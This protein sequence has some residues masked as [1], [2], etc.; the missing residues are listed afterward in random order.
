MV[1]VRDT[2]LLILHWQIVVFI[3]YDVLLDTVTGSDCLPV[4][5]Q[6]QQPTLRRS[7]HIQHNVSVRLLTFLYLNKNRIGILAL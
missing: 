7:V 2:C 6:Q 4:S 3:K 5:Q 1:N